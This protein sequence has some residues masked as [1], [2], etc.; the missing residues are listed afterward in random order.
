MITKDKIKERY[1]I[2]IEFK[3]IKKEDYEK[4]NKLLEQKKNEAMEQLK[5]YKN[6]EEIKMLPKLKCYSVIIIKD[7]VEAKELYEKI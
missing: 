5:I 3:Y 2:L 1:S 4:D 7:K 6:T